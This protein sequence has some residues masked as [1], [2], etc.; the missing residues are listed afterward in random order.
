MINKKTL[1]IL[2]LTLVV[3]VGA[4]VGVLYFWDNDVNTPPPSETESIPLFTGN[5]DDVAQMNVSVDDED[6]SFV[7]DRDKW[8]VKGKDIKLK[9]FDIDYLAISLSGVYA[10]SCVEENATDLDKYGLKT[11]FGTYE[12]LFSDGTVQKFYL[13]DKEQVTG[14]YFFKTENSPNVYLIHESKGNELSKKLDEYRD[15]AILEID[16][17]NLK[18]IYVKKGTTVLEIENTTKEGDKDETWSMLSP[19]RKTC[20]YEKVNSNIISKVSYMELKEFVDA[21]D[22]GYK[23]SGVENPYA[24]IMLTDN[25][26]NSQTIYVGNSNSDMRYIKTQGQVYLINS[27]SVSFVDI[28]PF[29][30]I[31]KFI[32]LEKIDDVSKIE[33]THKGK[34]HIATISGK[35]DNYVYKFNGKEVL[36]D[37]FK[38]D[39][40]QRIIALS[41]DD[42]AKNP[43][44]SKA[45]YTIK[46]YFRD[47][48]QK[49][50]EYCYYDDRSYSA[51]NEK[52]VC[53][54]IIRQKELQNMF[55]SLE[56]V[57][58][59][60]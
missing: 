29:L 23:V 60:R 27:N 14:S 10:K 50:T 1:I 20:D 43:K 4:C 19:L 5:S 39:I 35:K 18:K 52:G 6:F 51:F 7:K 54:F 53:E 38:R 11:P 2:A 12:L 40:Y 42:F 24:T 9:H 47:G 15:S 33:V 58:D 49:K 44:Y 41:A 3:L 56:N 34:T 46:F 16:A 59:G 37:T 48:S 8:R 30:Y 13:G 36:E 32:N 26:G 22:E 31:S 57:S 55:A 25:K 21:D 28:D 45:E 17:E